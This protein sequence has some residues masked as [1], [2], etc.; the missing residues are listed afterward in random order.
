[1]D[2]VNAMMENHMPLEGVEGSQDKRTWQPA[3][4]LTW[5]CAGIGRHLTTHIRY[6]NYITFNWWEHVHGFQFVHMSYF[7]GFPVFTANNVGHIIEAFDNNT[8]GRIV[9]LPLGRPTGVAM[10][11]VYPHVVSWLK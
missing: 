11:I 10:G 1:M 5:A 7:V 4:V 8:L 2:N 9:L 6:I 3:T